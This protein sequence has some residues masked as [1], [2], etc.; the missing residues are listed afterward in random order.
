MPAR[1]LHSPGPVRLYQKVRD[2]ITLFLDGEAEVEDYLLVML[3][4]IYCL[5]FGFEI[6][7]TLGGTIR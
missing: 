3:S 5:I 2:Y 7:D 1:I 4:M 6:L